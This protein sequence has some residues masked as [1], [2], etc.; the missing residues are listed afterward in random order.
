MRYG[1]TP[2]RS[3]R[4][5]PLSPAP[6]RRH[7]RGRSPSSATSVSRSPSRSPRDRSR[8]VHRLPVATPVEDVRKQPPRS[9]NMPLGMGR[10]EDAPGGGEGRRRN[11]SLISV[12]SYLAH[13][14]FSGRRRVTKERIRRQARKKCLL[15]C[16]QNLLCILL[17][18][19]LRYQERHGIRRLVPTEKLVGQT[20]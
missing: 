18:L 11:V 6:H 20:L 19:V 17:I 9:G 1:R 5:S 12:R 16:Y 7:S 15:Q 8:T 10:V 13:W 4:R 3:A 2:V 14:M